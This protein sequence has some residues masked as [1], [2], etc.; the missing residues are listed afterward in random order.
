MG[1]SPSNA[2]AFTNYDFNAIFRQHARTAKPA[3]TTADYNYFCFLI[4]GF[5]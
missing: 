2:M 4:H 1:G 3:K 5:I